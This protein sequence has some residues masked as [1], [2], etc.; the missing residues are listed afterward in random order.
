[1]RTSLKAEKDMDVCVTYLMTIMVLEHCEQQWSF[2]AERRIKIQI[3]VSAGQYAVSAR[4]LF[5]QAHIPAP[6]GTRF[7]FLSA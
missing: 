7:T 6:P 1:M 4:L 2:N 3:T 5:S